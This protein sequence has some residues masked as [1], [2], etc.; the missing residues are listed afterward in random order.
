MWVEG[1]CDSLEFF[2]SAF[3]QGGVNSFPKARKRGCWM[4]SWRGGGS[5]VC[6]FGSK[7]GGRFADPGGE[8]GL[9]GRNRQASLDR[10]TSLLQEGGRESGAG[11]STCFGESDLLGETRHVGLDSRV[12]RGKVGR[13]GNRV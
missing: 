3:A 13:G 2:F 5:R 1:C 10:E 11:E 8:A 9:P 4:G 6:W 7:G 12:R